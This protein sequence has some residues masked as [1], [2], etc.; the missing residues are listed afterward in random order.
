MDTPLGAT[1]MNTEYITTHV[2]P[3]VCSDLLLAEFHLQEQ[4]NR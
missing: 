1:V 4:N 3:M 2:L